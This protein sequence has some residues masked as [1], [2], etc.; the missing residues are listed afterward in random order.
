[1]TSASALPEPRPSPQA[2]SPAVP[3]DHAVDVSILIVTWNS[4]AWIER[5]LAALPAACGTLTWE[6]I[7]HDNASADATLR[8][9]AACQGARLVAAERNAGFA[10]GMNSAFR[11]AR[12][13]LLF[14]LNPDCEPAPGS[15]EM[16]VAHLRDR[17]ERGGAAPLL[18]GEDGSLQREFQLRRFPTPATLA[19]EI[20][21]AGKLFP[22][23][24]TLADYRCRDLDLSA[25]VAVEQPAGAALLLRRSAFESAGGFDES[26]FPAWFEDVDLCRRLSTANVV[27][28]VVPSATATH[29]GGVARDHVGGP[30]FTVI[31]YRNLFR[32]ALKW[33]TAA[34]CERIRW[35][36]VAGMLLRI[37]ATVAGVGEKGVPKRAMIRAYGAVLRDALRRWDE[38]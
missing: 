30:A 4:A 27:I 17:P 14:F 26:F 15:I 16:L 28:D 35:A 36:I 6:T 23:N 38:R 20:L 9:V 24:R 12:G 32:Y 33:F 21:L 10:A 31:W 13:E 37:V 22:A 29:R 3:D 25:P 18:V 19:A 8:L 34:E 7:V 1:M 2:T 11:H 5:C